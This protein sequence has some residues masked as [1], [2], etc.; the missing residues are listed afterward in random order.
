M[1]VV[2]CGWRFAWLAGASVLKSRRAGAKAGAAERGSVA[3]RVPIP[4]SESSCGWAVG[5]AV[6]SAI[7]AQ[8]VPVAEIHWSFPCGK[9][10]S[11]YGW[12]GKARLRTYQE[13]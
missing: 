7:T 1:G 2:L 12:N 9:P 11:L 8:L 6:L 10:L 13:P 5:T 4:H 3:P